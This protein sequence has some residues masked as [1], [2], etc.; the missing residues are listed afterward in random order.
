M[1][2]WLCDRLCD[3]APAQAVTL[4]LRHERNAKRGKRCDISGLIGSDRDEFIRAPQ[5]PGC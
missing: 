1:W 4:S 3:N 5:L 2:N